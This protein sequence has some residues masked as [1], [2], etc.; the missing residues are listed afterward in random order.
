[1][2]PLFSIKVTTFQFV[3][4]FCESWGLTLGRVLS[5]L[6]LARHPR[7]LEI[8]SHIDSDIVVTSAFND[9]DMVVAKVKQDQLK[10]NRKVTIFYPDEDCIEQNPIVTA[11]YEKITSDKH[12]TIVKLDQ[13]EYYHDMIGFIHHISVDPIFKITLEQLPVYSLPDKKQEEQE[14]LPDKKQEPKKQEPFTLLQSPLNLFP[15]TERLKRR[16]QFFINYFM[17]L[18]S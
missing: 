15:S 1:M 3:Q 4:L 6:D 12:V 13:A 18:V 8:D 17:Y 9:I 16:K 5:K 2:T 14:A 10:F 11:Q 7:Y